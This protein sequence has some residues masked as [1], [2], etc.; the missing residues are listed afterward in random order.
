MDRYGTRYGC[1]LTDEEFITIKRD[2]TSGRLAL[3]EHIPWTSGG[4]GNMSAAL[5]VWSLGMLAAKFDWKL[6]A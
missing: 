5:A 1:L 2:D 4:T 6:E 3:S